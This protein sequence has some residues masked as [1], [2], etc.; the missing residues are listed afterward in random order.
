MKEYWIVMLPERS[1]LQHTLVDR[2]YQVTPYESGTICSTS[3][4]GFEIDVDELY[5][6][7]R[8][9]VE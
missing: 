6:F 3:L 5:Q 4:D 2:K 8:D 1:I 7:L 9:D